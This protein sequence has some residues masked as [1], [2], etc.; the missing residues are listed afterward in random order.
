MKVRE[1]VT[2]KGW[3]NSSGWSYSQ[4]YSDKIVEVPDD[5]TEG[6]MDWSWWDVSDPV[7]GEDIEITVA[8]YREDYDPMFD[9][10]EP[11]VSWSIWE[12]ELR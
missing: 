8:Y 12:S 3:V 10:G 11:L 4:T 1:I 6:E 9:S 2:I 5:F 7:E